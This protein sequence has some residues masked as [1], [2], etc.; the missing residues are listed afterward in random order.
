MAEATF[1]QAGMAIDYTPTS[2]VAVGAVVVQVNL[3]GIATQAIATNVAGS[4]LVEGVFDF[5]KTASLVVSVGDLVYWDDTANAANKTSAG[6]TLI[7]KCVRASAASDT[8]VRVKL[9]Q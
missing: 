5:N 8:T 1:I 7:G 3:V 2:A 6:N 4:L 9:S